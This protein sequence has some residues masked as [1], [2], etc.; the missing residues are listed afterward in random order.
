MYIV[1]ID[2]K[3]LFLNVTDVTLLVRGIFTKKTQLPIIHTS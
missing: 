1:Y 3:T 2:K